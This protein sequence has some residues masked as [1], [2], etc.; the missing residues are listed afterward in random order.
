MEERPMCIFGSVSILS[1]AFKNI[2]NYFRDDI[3]VFQS[4]W[5]STLLI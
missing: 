1:L 4:D 2:S 5:Y 3:E